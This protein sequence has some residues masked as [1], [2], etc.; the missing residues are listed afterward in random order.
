MVNEG[1]ALKLKRRLFWQNL[2]AALA[3][4]GKQANR[5]YGAMEMHPFCRLRRR[6][7]RRGRF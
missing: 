1:G 4:G 3:G 7:P 5:A 2:G 6:L